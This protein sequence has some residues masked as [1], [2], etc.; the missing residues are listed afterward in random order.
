MF[1]RFQPRCHSQKIFTSNTFY[2]SFPKRLIIVLFPIRNP[3]CDSTNGGEALRHG[4]Q[5]IGCVHLPGYDQGGKVEFYEWNW[6]SQKLKEAADKAV[7]ILKKKELSEAHLE[8]I[9]YES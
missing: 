6:T 4:D 2:Y 7:S 1:S 3:T 5:I 9:S 8:L